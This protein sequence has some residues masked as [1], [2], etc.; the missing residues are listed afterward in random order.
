MT[1]TY[2]EV[3]DRLDGLREFRG[4]YREY[5]DFTNRS[6]NLPARTLLSRMEPLAP[7]TVDSLNR[8]NLGTIVTRE[9]PVRG[10]KKVKINLIRAIFRDRVRRHFNLSDR[11]PLA[12]LDQGVIRYKEL[13]WKKQLW[14]LN[15]LYWLFELAGFVADLPFLICRRAGYD[16][17][18]AE[19]VSLSK[20]YRLSVQILV[21]LA[22]AKATGL[23]DWI[24][25]DILGHPA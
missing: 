5:I 1:M 11:E 21:L 12:L 3:R 22:V 15:P 18:G 6:N 19:K 4:M 8:I 9:A 20:F 10:G 24:W 2:F 23:L 7:E 17:S 25:F 14:L 16:T 13:L